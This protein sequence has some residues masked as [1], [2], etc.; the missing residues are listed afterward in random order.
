MLTA[1]SE[2]YSSAPSTTPGDSRAIQPQENY[3]YRVMKF[4]S[5]QAMYRMLQLSVNKGGEE[6]S[7]MTEEELVEVIEVKYL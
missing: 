5:H 1:S 6:I 7:T 2:T 3:E 4:G